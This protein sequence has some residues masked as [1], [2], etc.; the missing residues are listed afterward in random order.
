MR[1]HIAKSL[2]K[3]CNAI[4]NAVNQYNAARAALTPK[5]PPLNWEKVPHFSFLEE[6]TLLQDMQNDIRSKEWALP[7]VRETM[8]ASR[9][10]IRAEE[11]L[12]NV[13][14]E[15]HR[16]HTSI[17][18]KD[19]LF[20]DVLEDPQSRG[21]TLYGAVQD[22]CRRRRAVNAHILAYLLRLYALE[23]FTGVS[24]P[25]EHAGEPREDRLGVAS[26]R[27]DTGAASEEVM[28]D[29]PMDINSMAPRTVAVEHMATIE[30]PI[31]EQDD[32]DDLESVDEDN[33]GDV[34]NLVERMSNIAIVM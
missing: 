16:V 14:R 10:V 1:T 25:G 2:Q 9:H 22:Y 7:L 5:R 24:G 34:T 29:T 32:R 17:R 23:G 11:E 8:R 27:G 4:C 18:D 19:I 33:S 31:V 6:F 20:T 12:E 26:C 3:R 21:D 13:N 30:V 15:A 28:A